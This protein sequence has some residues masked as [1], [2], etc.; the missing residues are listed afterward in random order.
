MEC[1]QC[2][3]D[4]SNDGEGHSFDAIKEYGKCCDC[5]GFCPYCRQDEADELK[6]K[7]GA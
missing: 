6:E 4:Y 3:E 5:L 7:D 1:P 2:K